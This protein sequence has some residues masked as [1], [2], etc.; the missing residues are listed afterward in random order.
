ML[1]S[2]SLKRDDSIIFLRLSIVSG[3]MRLFYLQLRS[4]YMR[5]VF[6][7][8]GGETVRKKDPNQFPDRGNR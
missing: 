2:N 8:F 7:T 1:E 4:C 3:W 5:F 6:F